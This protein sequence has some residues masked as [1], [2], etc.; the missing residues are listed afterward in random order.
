MKYISAKGNYGN[1]RKKYYKCYTLWVY[2]IAMCLRW[3]QLGNDI[4][5]LFLISTCCYLRQCGI[6]PEKL[7]LPWGCVEVVLDR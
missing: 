3:G 7:I 6:W 2:I 5:F 4:P 1:L